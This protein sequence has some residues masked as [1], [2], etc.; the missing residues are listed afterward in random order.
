MVAPRGFRL[1]FTFD[2]RD[3]ALD[4]GDA[5]R[6]IPVR[7]AI[8][9][10]GV[11]RREASRQGFLTVREH[12]QHEPPGRPQCGVHIVCLGDRYQHERWVQ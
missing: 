4:D 10:V 2:A 3:D 11:F 5:V 8:E 1:L 7:D 9:P 12:V 6:R